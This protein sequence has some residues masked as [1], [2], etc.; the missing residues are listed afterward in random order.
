MKTLYAWYS[1]RTAK[2]YGSVIYARADGT[3]VEVTI[4]C[5]SNVSNDGWTDK[6]YVG[7]V[8]RYLRKGQAGEYDLRSVKE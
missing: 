5:D 2:L 3:E 6:I 4:V 7:E 1:P 8:T